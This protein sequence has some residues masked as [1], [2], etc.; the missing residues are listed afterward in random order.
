MWP[1]SESWP[2]QPSSQSK[3]NF[4]G[5]NLNLTTQQRASISVKE[6][7]LLRLYYEKI[8]QNLQQ[9]NCRIIAKAYIKLVE[10]RKQVN[11]PYNGR[12]IV[13]GRTQQLDPETTKP[14]WWPHG[15]SHR[16]PDHLPKVE[17]IRLLVY[18]L[19]EMRETHGITTAR[20]KQCDQPI[21]RQILPV[22]RLQILDEAYRVREEEEKFLDGISD[23]KSVFISRTNLPQMV[24]DTSSGQSSPAETI[25]SQNI[26]ESE[27]SDGISSIDIT[28]PGDLPSAS[29]YNH[30]NP[31]SPAMNLGPNTQYQ[32][33]GPSTN[34]PTSP[35]ELRPKH[36][37]LSAGSHLID[38]TRP[39]SMTHYPYPG[40]SGIPPAPMQFYGAPNLS[41]DAGVPITQTSREGLSTETMMPYGHPYYFNY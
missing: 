41:Q 10:P 19:C 32:S 22:E 23:G 27:R 36:E 24:E 29:P 21:R 16:E 14:P 13:E 39:V 20:L 35:L 11:Y 4:G 30:S 8:F 31:Y 25:S 9:T 7:G 34:M 15:V 40:V 37:S 17:R 26:V 38:Q 1:S 2:L 3:K 5:R 18:M 28:H 33:V 6:R 12:K